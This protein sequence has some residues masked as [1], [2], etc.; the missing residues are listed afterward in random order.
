MEVAMVGAEDL[1]SP[2]MIAAATYLE[3]KGMELKMALV[4][5]PDACLVAGDRA[6]TPTAFLVGVFFL[7][8]YA[9]AVY[10]SREVQNFVRFFGERGIGCAYLRVETI[11]GSVSVQEYPINNLIPEKINS[12]DAADIRRDG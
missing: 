4:E 2:F 9:L 12:A 6:G 1:R 8:S 10:S 5:P 3:Q 7:R 11:A